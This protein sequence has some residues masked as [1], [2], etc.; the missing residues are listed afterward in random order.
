MTDTEAAALNADVSEI[1][2]V[3]TIRGTL[4][5]G[6]TY[7]FA[8]LNDYL[9]T[10]AQM[11][12]A[13]ATALGGITSADFYLIARLQ[14]S[15]PVYRVRW[16]LDAEVSG[17]VLRADGT[18]GADPESSIQL[19]LRR[20]PSGTDKRQI[21]TDPADDQRAGMPYRDALSGLVP[22]LLL[23]QMWGTGPRSITVGDRATVTFTPET[24]EYTGPADPEPVGV[25]FS[26]ATL[27][28][29]PF[30]QPRDNYRVPA[31]WLASSGAAEGEG[32]K[33]SYATEP[34][35]T[36]DDRW[37]EET[38]PVPPFTPLTVEPPWHW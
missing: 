27:A 18:A 16:I 31:L 33:I 1:D 29:Y 28:E 10:Q 17:P 11:D 9:A 4:A 26:S 14:P 12:A 13:T 8:S 6:S 15:E 36:R 5:T 30:F 34:G 22:A 32:W 38:E 23:Q 3:A 20:Y 19:V 2:Y 25:P 21:V 37:D 24:L 7:P 35:S